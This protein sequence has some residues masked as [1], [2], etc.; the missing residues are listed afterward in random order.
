MIQA[1]EVTNKL[2][3]VKFDCDVHRDLVTRMITH[4]Y[5]QIIVTDSYTNFSKEFEKEGVRKDCY[6]IV[7]NLK[8]DGEEICED[9]SLRLAPQEDVVAHLRQ[10]IGKT[11]LLVTHFPKPTDDV[12]KLEALLK[13]RGADHALSHYR[14][15]RTNFYMALNR[16]FE[17]ASRRG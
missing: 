15:D 8:R 13:E 5:G 16:T 4:I 9:G 2:F 7:Y 17:N 11:P 12:E 6:G 1:P 14:F 3:L 10:M